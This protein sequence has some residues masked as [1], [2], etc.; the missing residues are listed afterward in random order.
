MTSRLLRASGVLVLLM[1]AVAGY[2]EGSRYHRPD[3]TDKGTVPPPSMTSSAAGFT[4][5]AL[6]C[7]RSVKTWT[8][9]RDVAMLYLVQLDPATDIVAEG[10]RAGELQ[11]V[12]HLDLDNMTKR[13]TRLSKALASCDKSPMPPPPEVLGSLRNLVDALHNASYAWIDKHEPENQFGHTPKDYDY[14][15]LVD[16]AG[17][18]ALPCLLQ[19]PEFLHKISWPATYADAKR[20]IDLNATQTVAGCAPQPQDPRKKWV[21]LI[22][23][24]KYLGVPDDSVTRGRFLVVVPGDDYDR[25]VQ[26]GLMTDED[27]AEG[28]LGPVRNISVVA[29]ATPASSVAPAEFDAMADYFRCQDAQ[30]NDGALRL[31]ENGKPVDYKAHDR[32]DPNHAISAVYRLKLSH[33][34]DDCQQCHKALPLGIHPEKVYEFAPDGSLRVVAPAVASASA[35]VLNDMIAH[36]RRQPLFQVDSTDRM[37]ASTNYGTIGLGED[38]MTYGLRQRSI[39][40]LQRCVAPHHLEASSVERVRD[41]MNCGHCHNSQSSGVGLLNY[42]LATEKRPS[43]LIHSAPV[44]DIPLEVHN[45]NIVASRILSGDMPLA[46][47]HSGAPK[48]LTPAER[49]AL[50]DC[51]SMEYLD[52]SRPGPP[53]GL[54]MDAMKNQGP[55]DGQQPPETLRREQEPPGPPTPGLAALLRSRPLD[56][57]RGAV[58]FERFC[59]DCHST[60]P[61]ETR[62]G[63]SLA[64]L[65]GRNV[66]AAPGYDGYSPGLR[67]IGGQA[68]SGTLKRLDWD[69]QA[70]STFLANPDAFIGSH[71]GHG[72]SEMRMRMPDL[73][74]ASAETREGIVDYLMTL[75]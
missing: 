61:G 46:F 21:Q 2:G 19:S 12:R 64:G 24:S 62:F 25:W 42:P 65:P 56:A 38:P 3:A 73:D 70:L 17:A 51:L 50:F 6:L 31:G 8:A 66:G 59:S 40:S 7:P 67:M 16:K 55:G 41:S 63:P 58:D 28:H 15:R 54:F 74:R 10:P 27:V 60:L 11:G 75:K 53:R 47:P 48:S 14:L 49:A 13:A 30:C 22:Y 72:K 26:F 35:A 1:A 52:M 5:T 57:A 37:A 32:F 69:R 45:P 4:S 18:L 44:P 33:E 36:Y 9:W 23:R 43:E 39:A 34:T 29:H 68:T 20:M 71:G